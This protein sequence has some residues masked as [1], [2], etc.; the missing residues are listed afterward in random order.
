MNNLFFDVSIN[1]LIWYEERWKE[2]IDGNLIHLHLMCEGKTE[3]SDF[4]FVL[5]LWIERVEI[6]WCWK[7]EI[8]CNEIIPGRWNSVINYDSVALRSR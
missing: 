1:I 5:S 6:F 4:F 7:A 2:E 8:D 3:E